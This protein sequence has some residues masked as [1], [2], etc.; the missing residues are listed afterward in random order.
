MIK[1]LTHNQFLKAWY[2]QMGIN[3]KTIESH[4][5]DIYNALAEL[6]QEEVRLTG[7]IRLKNIGKFYLIET[8]GY[9]RKNVGALHGMDEGDTY[10]VP[11]HFLPKFSAST[12]FKD[13]VNDAIVSKEGRRRQKNNT[14]TKMDEALI[15]REKAKQVDDIRRILERKKTTGEKVADIDRDS[16]M[17]LRRMNGGE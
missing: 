9:E 4:M 17:F 10:Y 15:E 2:K 6:I 3:N 7:E 5:G 14:T 11:K 16:R 8:G 1:T 12:N 13:F